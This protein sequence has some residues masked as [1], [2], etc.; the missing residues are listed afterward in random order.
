M[1][2]AAAKRVKQLHSCN[3][4][5]FARVAGGHNFRPGRDTRLKYRYYHQH[6]GFAEAHEQPKCVGCNRC[7]SVCL[8]GISP[9]AVIK[10]LQEEGVR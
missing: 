1:D 8:A 3:F 6:R 2:G 10:D 7:G 5:D 4:I 9:P